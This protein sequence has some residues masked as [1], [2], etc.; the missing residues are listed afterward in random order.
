M[1][2]LDHLARAA[3]RAA[4]RPDYLAS[5]CSADQLMAALGCDRT[6]AERLRLCRLPRPEQWDADCAAIA[7]Y[8]GVDAA[9]LGEALRAI[10]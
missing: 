3:D 1:P 7:S 2:R 6:T 9:A 10:G 4:L 8:A 5:R